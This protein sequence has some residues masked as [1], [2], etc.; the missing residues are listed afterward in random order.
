GDGHGTGPGHSGG[1]VPLPGESLLSDDC[2][3]TTAERYPGNLEICDGVD[4]DCDGAIDDGATSTLLY[5]D[6]DG[7]GYGDPA[8]PTA[9]GCGSVAGYVANALDCDD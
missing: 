5:T 1:C 2:D 3:D 8:G 7:D 9:V 6:A 4:N